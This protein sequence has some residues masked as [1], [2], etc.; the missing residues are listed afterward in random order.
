MKKLP[1]VFLAL[2]AL[3]LC[4]DAPG[5]VEI[6]TGAQLKAYSKSLAPKVNAQKAA[7]QPVSKWN[8]SSFMMVHR[9][10]DGE[11]ELHQTQA[12]V[13]I[14]QTG[15]GTL[16]F[17][18]TVNNPRDTAP[19]EVRGPSMSG[20]EERKLS[21]GDVVHVPAKVP[22]QVLVPSGHEITYAVVKIDEK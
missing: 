4:A 16:K 3:A 21:A 14:V 8:N 10:G 1:V 18:G 7:I 9:E 5:G 19:N 6:Y 12:D 22:H 17:G 20:G 15:S 2:L 13:M 11:V